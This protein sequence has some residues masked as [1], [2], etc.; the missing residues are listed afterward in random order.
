M[1]RH[2]LNIWDYK[3]RSQ[4]VLDCYS[5]CKSRDKSTPGIPHPG[6]KINLL[7]SVSDLSCTMDHPNFYLSLIC[8]K[9]KSETTKKGNENTNILK[10]KSNNPIINKNPNNNPRPARPERVSILFGFLWNKVINNRTC[11]A[12]GNKI[13]GWKTEDG[14][15]NI[16][17]TISTSTWKR[18]WCWSLPHSI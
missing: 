8:W 9:V 10:F 2:N 5:N 14:S 17:E 4:F 13:N 1:L 16:F 11:P 3:D 6:Q 12:N 7:N 15:V 18:N